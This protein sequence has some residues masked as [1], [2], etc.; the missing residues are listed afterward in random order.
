MGLQES[1]QWWMSFLPGKKVSLV[2]AFGSSELAWNRPTVTSHYI[3]AEHLLCAQ[4]NMYGWETLWC[5]N[6][7]A[8][9]ASVGQSFPEFC[10][11][12]APTAHHI[13][14]QTSWIHSSLPHAQESQDT[15]SIKLW[16]LNDSDSYTSHHLW[17]QVGRKSFVNLTWITIIFLE[18]G[19]W[20]VDLPWEK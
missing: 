7:W 16:W 19:M 5:P 20:R 14:L 15:Y 8:P 13:E 6:V 3:L 11:S 10:L 2:P 12:P 17:T 18:L 9:V 4:N 1:K